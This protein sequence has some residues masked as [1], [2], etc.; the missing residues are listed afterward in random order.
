MSNFAIYAC[1]F[2]IIYYNIELNKNVEDYGYAK[3]NRYQ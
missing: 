3:K 2:P 1:N